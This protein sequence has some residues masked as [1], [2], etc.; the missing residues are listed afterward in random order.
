MGG[1]NKVYESLRFKI[2]YDWPDLA[3]D[4]PGLE[5]SSFVVFY[6]IGHVAFG[7]V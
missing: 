6:E 3:C 1:C 2:Y 4:H 7:F 5:E